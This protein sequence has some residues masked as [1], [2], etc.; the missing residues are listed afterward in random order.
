MARFDSFERD[1]KIATAGM[2]P[3]AISAALAK[4]ARSELAKAIAAGASPQYDRYVNG[5]PGLAEEAVVAPGSILYVFSNWPLIINAALA[6]LVKR[7]PRKSGRFAESFIVIVGGQ[8]V[9]NYAS[10]PSDAE[11]I[12]TDF[13]PYIRKVEGGLLGVKRRRVFDGT[14]NAMNNR[15]RGAFGFEAKFLNIA[16]GVHPMIPY[17]LKGGDQRTASVD[18]LARWHGVPKPVILGWRAQG[19]NLGTVSAK[20]RADRAAGQPITYPSIVINAL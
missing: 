10:I 11:V 13:Q 20:P 8:P 9:T 6:E 1:L 4:Y 12:I 17:V 16:S 18:A 14:K 7:S 3:A 19:K 2:E 15:F 5:V